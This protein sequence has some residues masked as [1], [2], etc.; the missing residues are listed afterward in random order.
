MEVDI[1]PGNLWRGEIEAL[2]RLADETFALDES[3]L[4]EM[5]ADGTMDEVDR[6][7]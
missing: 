4:G 6:D 2:W 3:G 7:G 5:P 1:D